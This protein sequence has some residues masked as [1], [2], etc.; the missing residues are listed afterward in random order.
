VRRAQLR[1]VLGE[2]RNRAGALVAAAE[3]GQP[4]QARSSHARSNLHC[5][6]G[7]KRAGDPA[8]NG[9]V[10]YTAVPDGVRLPKRR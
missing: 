8:S 6:I 5:Q 1:N 3:L 4:G 2:L 9:N 10:G 7:I